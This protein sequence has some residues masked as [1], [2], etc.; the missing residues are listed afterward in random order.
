MI[1]AHQSFVPSTSTNSMRRLRIPFF[2]SP[3]ILHLHAVALR[4]EIMCP[5]M[6]ACACILRSVFRSISQL[7]YYFTDRCI[8]SA[9]NYT[10]PRDRRGGTRA[11]AHFHVLTLVLTVY[12][13]FGIRR[14]DVSPWR[15]IQKFQT[16]RSTGRDVS[17][18]SA[19]PSATVIIP[20]TIYDARYGTTPLR[21][22]Y[23]DLSSSHS[24]VRHEDICRGM[25]DNFLPEK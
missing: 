7:L 20:R 11:R 19:S 22:C 1:R 3:R 21:R 10:P 8:C 25:P 16:V 17:H 15:S 24:C 14:M 18:A 13:H 6:I 5:G 23:F 2:L 9:A 4:P 12:V